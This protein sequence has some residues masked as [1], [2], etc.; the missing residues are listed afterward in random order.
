MT[1]IVER[2]RAGWVSHQCAEEAA[3]EIERLWQA[4]CEIEILANAGPANNATLNKISHIADEALC[5]RRFLETDVT[6]IG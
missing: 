6:S 5:L 1:D 4:L 3:D 2:L